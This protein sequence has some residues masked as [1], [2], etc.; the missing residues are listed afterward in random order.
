MT[1]PTHVPA[2]RLATWSAALLHAGGLEAE[3]ARTVA[4]TLVDTSLR[5]VDSH[6]V[7]RIPDYVAR[8]RAGVLNGRPRPRVV[9][10]DGAVALVDGDQGPGQIAGILATDLSIELARELGV[11]VVGV[12]R[13]AHYGAAA[14]YSR[15]AAAAGLIGM[16]M[17]N[18]E[19]S[20]IPYGGLARA[21][22]TNP[23]SLAA[24][25]GEAVFDLDLAT[26]QVALNRIYNAADE[27]RAIPEG[28][29]VDAQGQPTT[30]PAAV[31]AGVPLGGYKG[32]VLAVMVEI[33]C[34][35]LPG[36]GVTHA[37]GEHDVGQDVGHFHLAID[38]ERTVGR[39]R[40]AAVLG[41]LV[42]ELRASRPGPGSDEVLAPGDPE[43]RT[44]ARRERDGVP[45]VPTLWATLTE[46][47]EEL[48]VDRAGGLSPAAGR[49][50]RKSAR[51]FLH[52][53]PSGS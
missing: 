32:Y 39:D 47:G 6:G 51:N 42:D 5:G 3:A 1:D 27:G 43:A 10:R 11:G 40:F 4:D 28:W 24:P 50:A 30:D 12:R 29:G 41:G 14:F 8:L 53:R 20:V 16:S 26:S 19:P 18:S 33:L 23:I 44:R 13:S 34:G 2:D 48:G 25:A 38:P 7:A 15:R 17:T 46:L 52:R 49:S 36:A 35:V 45:L 9:R 21:L 37:V 22:G 31:N